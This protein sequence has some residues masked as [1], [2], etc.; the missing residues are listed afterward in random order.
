MPVMCMQ[1]VRTPCRVEVS[2]GE[3][4]RSPAEQ[5]E[6]LEIV[7]PRSAVGSLIGAAVARI[8]PGRIEHIS[9]H[10]AA[11]EAVFEATETQRDA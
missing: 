8:E 10:I 2:C 11:L 3:M 7:L 6:S 1:D 5:C 4:G 9:L